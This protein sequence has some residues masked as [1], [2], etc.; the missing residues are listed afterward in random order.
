MTFII[1][2]YMMA[3]MAISPLLNMNGELAI[4]IA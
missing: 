4:A 1:N 2:A 3:G